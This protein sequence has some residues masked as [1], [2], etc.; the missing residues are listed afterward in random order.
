MIHAEAAVPSALRVEEVT[1][2]SGPMATA[3]IGAV[4]AVA[5]SLVVHPDHGT[6]ARTT[7]AMPHEVHVRPAQVLAGAKTVRRS[8][9]NRKAVMSAPS[10]RATL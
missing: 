6:H 4:K 3:T 7:A 1:D 2:Q 9:G 10:R 5:K 8:R